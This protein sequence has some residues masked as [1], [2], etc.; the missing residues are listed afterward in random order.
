MRK[1]TDKNKRE[2][3]IYLTKLLMGARYLTNITF[4][5]H[6]DVN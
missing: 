4:N 2:N 1:F 3:K 5:V 6:N